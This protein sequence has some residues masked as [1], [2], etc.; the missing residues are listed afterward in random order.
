MKTSTEK[1]E[2][3]GDYAAFLHALLPNAQGFMFH[4]RHGGLFWHDIAPDTSQLND[5][6]HGALNHTLESAEPKQEEGRIQLRD[7]TAYF[8]RL[9]SDQ[10][11][12]LGVLTALV[13]RDAGSTFGYSRPGHTLSCQPRKQHPDHH[14]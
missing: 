8:M 12:I 10:G 1:N 3:F 14:Y 4:D 9:V 6:Y 5:A 11:R 2:V 7:S 13:D